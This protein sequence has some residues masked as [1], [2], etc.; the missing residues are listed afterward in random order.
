MAKGANGTKR[1]YGLAWP[2]GKATVEGPQ[3]PA[4]Y[5]FGP[6]ADSEPRRY[7]RRMPEGLTENEKKVWQRMTWYKPY[8]IKDVVTGLRQ[9]ASSPKRSPKSDGEGCKSKT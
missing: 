1:A 7:I 8:P 9:A 4:I 2:K 3:K 6:R 5:E